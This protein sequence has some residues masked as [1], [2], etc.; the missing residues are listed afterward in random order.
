MKIISIILGKI[1][2]FLCK[3]MGRGSAFPGSFA[4]KINKNILSCFEK[5]NI[6]IA[7]TGSS[8]KGSTTKIIYDV[9]TQSQKKV[10]YNDKGSNELS[11]IITTLL[12]NSTI[13]GKT[14]V[15]AAVFEIDERYTKHVFKSMEPNYVVI[16]NITRDQ[17]PRQRNVDFI[18]EEIK[19]SL[20]PNMHLILNADDPYLQKFNM[21]N[22]YKVSYYGIAKTVNS[23][24]QNKF[25][26]LNITYCPKCYTKL[27][28]NY[29]HF[30][31]LGDYYC[32]NCDF[33]TPEKDFEIT[34]INKNTITINNTYKIKLNNEMLFNQYNILAAITTLSLCGINPQK[35]SQ[36][37]ENELRNEKIY[38]H[39]NLNN[40][41]VFIMNNKNENATTFNQS[42]LYTTNNNNLKTIVIG[43]WQIS[44]RYDFDDLSWLYDIEFE[45][46]KNQKIDKII[47]A[48][49]QRYE[50]ALRL[51]Y[52]SIDTK[53]II[54]H[55]DLYQAKKDILNS[56]GDI[57]AILNFDY[58]KPFNEIMEEK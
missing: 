19:K 41:N 44:R 26:A 47:V 25:Q 27:K 55:E 56:Q 45:L 2:L 12:Q 50:L 34:N 6:V 20:T 57:Y 43:W 40:R 38:N 4:Y 18:F 39:I 37:I 16:T 11:A 36:V 5:P 53:K 17:P 7:V 22:E 8:G 1:V 10:A 54:I 32:P 24:Q 42:L 48:G 51:K 30:E 23:Y 33:K 46:L 28:Y 9:L 3:L 29:Y 58:I 35:S 14:K 13:T 15:D 49:P 52:A 21:N 31:A